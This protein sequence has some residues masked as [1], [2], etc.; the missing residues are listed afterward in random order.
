MEA[1]L[2]RQTAWLQELVRL[3][4][5]QR[6]KV[7]LLEQALHPL[8][9]VSLP[10]PE[11]PLDLRMLVPGRPQQVTEIP[12]EALMEAANQAPILGP[13]P[14]PEDPMPDPLVEIS[15]RLGLSRQPTSSPSS[16]S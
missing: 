4:A 16:P 7:E 8:Q 6:H 14:P 11:P 5:Q 2:R 9:V 1:K 13:E 10:E 15:Q 12:F 3:E